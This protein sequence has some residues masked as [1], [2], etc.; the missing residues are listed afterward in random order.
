[1]SVVRSEPGVPFRGGSSLDAGAII[2]LFAPELG[3]KLALCF[4]RSIVVLGM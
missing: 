4:E 2:G 3:K 1:M